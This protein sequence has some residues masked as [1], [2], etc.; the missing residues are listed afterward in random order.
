MLFQLVYS[1]QCNYYTEKVSHL[2]QPPI[3]DKF[4]IESFKSRIN[5][6]YGLPHPLHLI[7]N[8]MNKAK[9]KKLVKEKVT[10]YWQKNLSLEVLS[11]SSIIC[12][13]PD[14][15]SISTSHPIWDTVGCNPY[16]ISKATILAQMISGQYR[17]DHSTRFW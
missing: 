7:Q 9:F 12:F 4:E 5:V 8:P 14:F 11:R 17:T 2:Y 15:H 13:N 10:E 1:R 6:S 3:K 16:E